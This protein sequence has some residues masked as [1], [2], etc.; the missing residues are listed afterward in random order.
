MGTRVAGA[1]L[2]VPRHGHGA[3]GHGWPFF[4]CPGAVAAGVLPLLPG[5]AGFVLP[6]CWPGAVAEGLAPVPGASVPLVAL[7]S[8]PGAV[9]PGVFPLLPG[10]SFSSPAPSC[11]SDGVVAV[12]FVGDVDAVGAD[13]DVDAVGA[14]DGGELSVRAAQKSAIDWPATLAASAR[15]L[16]ATESSLAPFDA[17][18][19]YAVQS[20]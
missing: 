12:G 2:E 8:R 5:F 19:A 9:A 15:F 7:L 17:P 11:D 6:F 13:G 20:P 16:N 4:W 1:L 18:A 14:D 10:S 3:D